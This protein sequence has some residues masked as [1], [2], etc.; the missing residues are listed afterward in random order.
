M[1][2]TSII[3]PLFLF[4]STFLISI[5]FCEEDVHY[6][7]GYREVNWCVTGKDE[8]EL[9]EWPFSQFAYLLRR[10][11]RF[12]HDP[13]VRYDLRFYDIVTSQKDVGIDGRLYKTMH[14]VLKAEKKRDPRTTVNEIWEPMPIEG[15]VIQANANPYS[16]AI[17]TGQFFPSGGYTRGDPNAYQTAEI[18]CMDC[19]HKL[20]A[21]SIVCRK[22]AKIHVEHPTLMAWHHLQ[23][24]Y[25][26]SLEDPSQITA[27]PDPNSGALPPPPPPFD[28]DGKQTEVHANFRFYSPKCS[29]TRRM[30]FT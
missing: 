18:H 1:K 12:K 7:I 8:P 14:V 25:N 27:T 26:S 6:H 5:A 28:T 29:P 23:K 13:H 30:T 24:S 4:T 17:P 20:W 21:R 16:I 15:L 22:R 9:H 10:T 11:N 3:L 2:L 19:P